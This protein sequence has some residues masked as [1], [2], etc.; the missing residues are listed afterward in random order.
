MRLPKMLRYAVDFANFCD[1]EGHKPADV[2]D[3]IQLCR[4]AARA[5]ER[6]CSDPAAP[7]SDPACDAVVSQA[8]AMGYR[9]EWNGLYPSFI[10][11]A[12]FGVHLPYPD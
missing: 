2:A 10:N 12:G 7:S 9:V 8:T 5:N 1:R 11:A 3:L 6:E 4:K